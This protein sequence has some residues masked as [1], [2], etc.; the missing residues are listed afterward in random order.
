MENRKLFDQ[1]KRQVMEHPTLMD[2]VPFTVAMR[3]GMALAQLII[4]TTLSPHHALA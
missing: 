2:D 3:R 4:R 1:A